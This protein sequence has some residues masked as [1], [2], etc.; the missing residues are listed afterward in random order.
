M[1]QRQ[2]PME[3]AKRNSLGCIIAALAALLCFSI[4]LNIMS[5]VGSSSRSVV[6]NTPDLPKF[7]EAL[8]QPASGAGKTSNAKIVQISLRGIISSSMPGDLGETMV[9]DLKMQLRQAV[10]D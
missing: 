4:F 6:L 2:P 8:A 10:E 3:K 9:E 7:D 5:W 1:G